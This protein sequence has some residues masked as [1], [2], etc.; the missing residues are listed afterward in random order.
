MK[1]SHLL[2]V[3]A[4][5]LLSAAGAKASIIFDDFNVNE[6]HFN[7][8]PNFSSTTNF[9]SASTADRI[10]SDSLEGAGSEQLL[11][12]HSTATTNRVRFLSGGG[13]PTAN[14]SF[15]TT[16]GTDGF[17]GYYYKV[18]GDLT[19]AV[20]TTLSLNLD[21]GTGTT[22]EADGATPKPINND[23][24]WHLV[25]WDL[26]A[27][28]QW[29]AI[30]GIGGGH[31]GALIDTNHTIDSIYMQ[32]NSASSGST[33]SVLVDFVAKSDS[34]SIAALVPTPEPASIGLLL[35]GLPLLL[36]RRRAA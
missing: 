24:A 34:G 2:A 6:G 28:N 4:V 36:R 15:N 35:A 1:L 30:T 27:T 14:V 21:G 12:V 11:L 31:G 13:A 23:G 32:L 7:L 26:D 29:G 18:V 19:K 5:L 8:A 9:T 25:E 33:F 3:T 10:T 17:I 20:G 16:A 22:A